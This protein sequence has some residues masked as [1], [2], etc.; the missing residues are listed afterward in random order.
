MTEINEN[1]TVTLYAQRRV[2]VSTQ[3]AEGDKLMDVVVVEMDDFEK[4][5]IKLGE[6]PALTANGEKFDNSHFLARLLGEKALL[7]KDI[8]GLRQFI[9]SPAID[10]IGEVPAMLLR[11]QFVIQNDFLDILDQRIELVRG[12]V[13]ADQA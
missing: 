2:V 6:F 13:F 12:N 10:N 1:K 4:D 3:V 8:E 9:A 7:E 5:F 11:Q